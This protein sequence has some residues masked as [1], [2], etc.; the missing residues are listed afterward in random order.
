MVGCSEQ[1]GPLA[2]SE[3][4]SSMIALAFLLTGI[5]WVALSYTYS[6]TVLCFRASLRLI[7]LDVSL[8]VVP[9]WVM[10]VIVSRLVFSDSEEY[11]IS[12]WISLF[13]TRA[14]NAFG[15]PL[16][17]WEHSMWAEPDSRCRYFKPD[18]LMS[19]MM[20]SFDFTPGE[21]HLRE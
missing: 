20:W 7:G 14:T 21:S 16:S 2:I 4:L 11:R 6:W 9:T 1:Q 17:S 18:H 12:C 19:W 13:R 10:K 3:Q 15:P 8:Q 5:W